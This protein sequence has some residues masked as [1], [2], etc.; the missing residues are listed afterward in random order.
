[1]KKIIFLMGVILSL[2]SFA[3]VYEKDDDGVE[4]FSNIQTSGSTEVNLTDHPVTVLNIHNGSQHKAIY[5]NKTSTLN[6]PQ[7]PDENTLHGAFPERLTDNYFDFY[8][9]VMNYI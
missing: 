3:T 1:M 5:W 2:N 6:Q 9:M 8:G 4:T 7:N